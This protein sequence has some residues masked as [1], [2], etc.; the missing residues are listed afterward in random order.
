LHL[1]PAAIVLELS[2]YFD[3][4][5]DLKRFDVRPPEDDKYL[6]ETQT[7]YLLVYKARDLGAAHD[8]F[9]CRLGAT[10]NQVR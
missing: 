5:A 8:E 10:V 3:R 9:C 1:S 4:L 6:A 2:P 7:R